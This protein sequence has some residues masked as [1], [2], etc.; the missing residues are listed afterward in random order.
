[1]IKDPCDQKVKGYLY[2]SSGVEPRNVNSKESDLTRKKCQTVPKGKSNIS[3]VEPPLKEVLRNKDWVLNK[4][5]IK[6]SERL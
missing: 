3:W 4:R 5:N 6:S 2:D 1:M